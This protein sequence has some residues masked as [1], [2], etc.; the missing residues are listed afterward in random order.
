MRL[1][2]YVPILR[3]LLGRRAARVLLV[4]PPGAGGVA[5]PAAALESAGLATRALGLPAREEGGDGTQAHPEDYDRVLAEAADFGATVAYFDG[6]FG[7]LPWEA[8]P[9]AP[10]PLAVAVGPADL[11][12]TDDAYATDRRWRELRRVCDRAALLLCV[13]TSTRDA[14]VARFGAT[15]SR[16]RVGDHAAALARPL[17]PPAT[18]APAPRESRAAWL[19]T[20]TTLREAEVP[21]LRGLGLETWTTKPVHRQVGFRSGD[22]DPTWDHGLT[23][24]PDDLARL[25][26]HNFYDDPITPPVA[27]ALNAHFGTVLTDPYPEKI[28]QLLE[29]FKGHVVIRAFGREMPYTY[30]DYLDSPDAPALRDAMRASAHRVWFAPCYESIIP[31]EGEFLRSRAVLLPVGL[32][33]RV[34]RAAGTW[35]GTDPRVLFVCP[36]IVTA[37]AYYGVIYEEF[38]R[39]YGQF[40]H[41]ISGH[42]AKPVPDPAVTGFL[43]DAQ[44]RR[45]FR[46]CRAMYYHSREPRHLHYHPLE[47][48]VS[49]MPV[50]YMRGG[51]MEH[52]DTGSRAGACD[53]HDEARDKLARLMAGDAALE[54]A[55]RKSQRS[56]VETFL[57]DSVRRAW[58]DE[59][60]GRVLGRARAAA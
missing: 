3:D 48:I 21:I 56:I 54:R 43:P 29:H 35:T 4:A 31:A 59:F 25:N 57:P 8:R 49:G 12:E 10:L 23:L 42:Q 13:D 16:C 15:P 26:A 37:A 36:S 24:P 45:L 39:E 50:V 51:L 47:A 58:A 27:D 30:G 44:M 52:F 9:D 32:P 40:P 17:T 41:V 5:G 34:L 22:G 33:D 55:I 6:P 60:V 38:K 18:P 11:A 20:H 28:L 2:K 1:L 53:T 14:L 46:E 19:L 7:V